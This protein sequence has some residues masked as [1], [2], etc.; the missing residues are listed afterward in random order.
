MGNLENLYSRL[1]SSHLP[2]L[3]GMRF[4]AVTLVI[5]AH[6]GI[7]HVPA[8]HGVMLFFVISGF[9]ITWLLLKENEKS[10]TISLKG[11]YRRRIF[12][13]FPA[14]YVYVLVTVLLMLFVGKRELPVW[15]IISSLFYFSNY[16]AA[17]Y[18]EVDTPFN[19][20]WS[21][22]VEEQ[23]YLF[24]PLVFLF[25][26]RNLGQLKKAIC[27][28]I[29]MSWAWRC[30]LVF[31]FGA[32]EHYIYNAFE[33]RLDSLMIGCLLAI[34]LRTQSHRAFWQIAVS[35]IH[36][37]LLVIACLTASIYFSKVSII[38][39]TTIGLAV[40]PMLMAML[41]AQLILFSAKGFWS[42]LEW[43]FIK[44]LGSI[45]YSLY[46]YQPLTTGSVPGKFAA[47]PVVVQIL[48][49]FAVTVIVASL[50]YHF[51]EKPFLLLKTMS[52]REALYHYRQQM[53]AF[54]YRFA[55]DK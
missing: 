15:H 38:Y 30:I 5:V 52:L 23:F 50:S 34:V 16:F 25:F 44:Y 32:S 21:L 9:L 54:Y 51:I 4:V 40:E 6:M 14:F 26:C 49:T 55:T 41:L 22:A 11:F 10:G 17:F 33:T 31:Y 28:L 48:A 42:W 27:G 3:D 12:R 53:R 37:P 47:F 29:V 35:G 43:S 18:P 24:F 20:T 13:I 7:R 19:H 1:N 2:A 46:L 39:H 45:S 8:G 36:I